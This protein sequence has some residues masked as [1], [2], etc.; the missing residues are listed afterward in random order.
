[1]TLPVIQ[2]PETRRPVKLDDP[3]GI[4]P[5]DWI[6]DLGTLHQVDHVDSIDTVHVVHFRFQAG[7]PHLAR[8]FSSSGGPVT[9]WRTPLD[10]GRSG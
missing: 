3:G 8:G 7:V 9:V 10:T 1:M 4:K 6:H 2:P 5:G